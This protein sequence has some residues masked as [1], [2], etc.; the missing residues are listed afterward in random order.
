MNLK[1]GSIFFFGILLSLASCNNSKSEIEQLNAK[2][3]SDSIAL[4]TAEGKDTV[5]ANYINTLGEIQDNL[6]SLRVKQK[7][8]ALT[9]SEN[10]PG[11]RQAILDDI[12]SIDNALIVKNK[13]INQLEHLLHKIKGQNAR[14]KKMIARLNEQIAE[15]T[16]EIE[17][18]HNQLNEAD[19]SL[20]D[21]N[22][23]FNDS[24]NVI[25]NQRDAYNKLN[26]DFNTVY[27]TFGTMRD[28]K[29]KGVITKS[30]GI[31][32][33]GSSPELN[34]LASN[35]NFTK[36]DRN[37]LTTIA[38]NAR[39]SRLVTTHPTGSYKIEKGGKTDNFVITDVQKFWGQSKYLVIE[40]K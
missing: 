11:R 33:I 30:G 8:L 22:Q 24:M 5:I 34:G 27:Y 37:M 2:I 26:T 19:K 28:L 32:G 20:T 29:K 3:K 23:R 39:F 16:K 18:L 12:K 1:T 15:K 6:D 21:L 31:L 38:L 14:D 36:T 10:T 35:N 13:K 25:N 17:D 7:L 9:S 40:V 4:K